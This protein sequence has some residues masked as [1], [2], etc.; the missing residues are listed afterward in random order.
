MKIEKN[1]INDEVEI[2]LSGRLDTVTS[3]DFEKEIDNLEN[4]N[5]KKLIINMKEIQYTSSAGLRVLLKSQ[6]L[7]DSKGGS[8]K[9]INVN[10][11]VM[12]V[13]E[14]TGFN[15]MLTIE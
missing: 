8:M 7:M 3:T 12:E 2:V 11:I 5:V 4:L 15:E 6:K 9:L 10:E 13:F 14:I 1:I